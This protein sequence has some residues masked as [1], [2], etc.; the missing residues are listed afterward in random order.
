MI[1][2]DLDKNTQFMSSFSLQLEIWFLKQLHY[3]SE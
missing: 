2:G 1:G 3:F